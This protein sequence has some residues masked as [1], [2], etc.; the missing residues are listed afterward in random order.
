MCSVSTC[1]IDPAILDMETVSI[2]KKVKF[3]KQM[4]IKNHLKQH[5]LCRVKVL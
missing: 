3:V 5:L 2:V 4:K 1:K